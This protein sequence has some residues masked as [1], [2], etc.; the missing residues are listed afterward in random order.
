[1]VETIYIR[2]TQPPLLSYST[3][4]PIQLY[5]PIIWAQRQTTNAP[6]KNKDKI[7][8]VAFIFSV[9]KY[10]QHI[11]KRF[12]PANEACSIKFF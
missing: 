5:S 11:V 6:Q 2:R 7:G 3:S 4:Q 8:F 10:L 9:P 1:M 12:A